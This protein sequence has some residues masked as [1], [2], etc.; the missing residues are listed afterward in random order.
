M[1]TC[2][3][4]FKH[5]RPSYSIWLDAFMQ[6]FSYDNPDPIEMGLKFLSD[7]AGYVTGVRF[8]KAIGV[9]GTH[10][11]RLRTM[12]GVWPRSGPIVSK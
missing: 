10:I 5:S 6:E 12:S 9:T 3:K 4:T 1:N 2:R 7:V 8:F 11:G